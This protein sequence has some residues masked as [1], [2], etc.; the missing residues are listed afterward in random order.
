MSRKIKWGV[1]GTAD[2]AR[3]CTIPG[4]KKAENCC[5]FHSRNCGTVEG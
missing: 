2:I 1:L 5:L 3:C 4:M